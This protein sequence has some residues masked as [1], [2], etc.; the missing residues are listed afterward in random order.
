MVALRRHV[1]AQTSAETLAQLES[2][3]PTGF[4]ETQEEQRQL[5]QRALTC[6]RPE[7]QEKTWEAFRLTALAGQSPETAAMLLKL[8]VNAVYIAR[9]R[10]LHR[11][12]EELTGLLPDD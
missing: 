3:V 9:C 7:F 8:S 12:R 6:L 10:V 4:L 11:L 2:P 5:L 1:S